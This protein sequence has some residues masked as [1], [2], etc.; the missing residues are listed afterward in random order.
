MARIYRGDKSISGAAQLNGG[1]I[2]MQNLSVL[3]YDLDDFFL[4]VDEG[5]SSDLDS[6]GRLNLSNFI[7]QEVLNSAGVELST[8]DLKN[9]FGSGQT[10]ISRDLKLNR[11]PQD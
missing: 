5:S 1:Y 2:P 10:F 8:E 7:T 6:E 11:T 9:I 4:P 3:D